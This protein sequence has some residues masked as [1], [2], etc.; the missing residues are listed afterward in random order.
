[1]TTE[2]DPPDLVLNVID[3]SNPS[4]TVTN[5]PPLLYKDRNTYAGV[6][7][8]PQPVPYNLLFEIIA[9]DSGGIQSIGYSSVFNSGDPCSTVSGFATGSNFE[10]P[11]QTLPKNPDGTVPSLWP[12]FI[13]VTSQLEDQIICGPKYTLV[14]PGTYVVTAEATNYSNKKKK[15]TWYVNIGS[16]GVVL[17]PAP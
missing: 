15:A 6:T 7:P 10:V 5:V 11:T 4:G 16:N 14:I 3:L 12:G 13:S 9:T 1:L 8:D 17:P 2:K